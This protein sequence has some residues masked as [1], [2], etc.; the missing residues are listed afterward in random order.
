MPARYSFAA[1]PSQLNGD[2]ELAAQT[3]GATGSGGSTERYYL[4]KWY[5]GDSQT[6]GICTKCESITIGTGITP[7]A[8]LLSIT[9]GNITHANPIVLAAGGTL[10][11]S[12]KRYGPSAQIPQII[13]AVEEHN[14]QGY[15]QIAV[16]ASGTFKAQDSLP[17]GRYYITDN[18]QANAGF[19]KVTRG[20]YPLKA[21]IEA[22]GLR[23]VAGHE[24]T[25]TVS[26]PPPPLVH[27][28]ITGTEA[29]GHAVHVSTGWTSPRIVTYCWW[30]Y[31]TRSP[32]GWGLY[33]DNMQTEGACATTGFT[34]PTS[35]DGYR[36]AIGV[37]VYASAYRTEA[38]STPEAMKVT[39][40]GNN[41]LTTGLIQP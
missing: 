24:S 11:G 13:I 37:A 27:P 8:K 9:A 40:E 41:A 16:S 25:L 26:G 12:I 22:N 28:A 5:G 7:K 6:A 18:Y 19:E 10:S 1:D 32:S 17:P 36:P 31:G 39:W 15:A 35:G 2:A 30:T 4:E 20:V 29:D 14:G 38:G 23:I 33:G 34:V 21:D 3:S